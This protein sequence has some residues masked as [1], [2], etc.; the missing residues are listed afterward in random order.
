MVC[1]NRKKAIG[2]TDES[3]GLVDHKDRRAIE[4]EVLTAN[5]ERVRRPRP[6]A[7]RVFEA[8]GKKY[9]GNEAKAFASCPSLHAL[10]RARLFTAAKRAR[11]RRSL[12]RLPLALQLLATSLTTRERGPFP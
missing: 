12:E 11:G 8:P 3:D 10:A 4:K 9:W 7:A 1:P 6:R 5:D 2:E